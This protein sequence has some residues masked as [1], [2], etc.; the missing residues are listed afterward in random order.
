ML[1][2][3]MTSTMPVART[4]ISQVCTERR[5]LKVSGGQE[6]PAVEYPEIKIEADPDDQQRPIMPS[7]R[8]SISVARRKRVIASA[9]ALR[10]SLDVV[11]CVMSA[12]A[13]PFSHCW[14]RP[15]MQ[16]IH[17]PEKPEQLR[18]EHLAGLTTPTLIV[19][20]T[21]DPFGTR[22][23]VSSYKLSNNIDILWLED[24][25]HDLSRGRRSP[26][27]QRLII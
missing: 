18:T 2:V 15:A 25:D 24:G 27:S 22:P 9:S 19:Q 11:D 20:G 8:V 26:A 5:F 7:R 23:E 14:A 3:T 16:S 21:R 10:G 13:L 6:F 12:I 17:P 4:A 1:R